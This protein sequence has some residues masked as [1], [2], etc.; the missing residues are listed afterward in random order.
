[1][2]TNQFLLPRSPLKRSQKTLDFDIPPT[3]LR[4]NT[5]N[6]DEGQIVTG[7][8]FRTTDDPNLYIW[9]NEP[10]HDNTGWHVSLSNY[11]AAER[12]VTI[13][14]MCINITE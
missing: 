5:V 12:S 4:V 13:Y 2:Y 9:G 11:G 6:C 1:M 3:S 8:G 10:L 14:A 7:G